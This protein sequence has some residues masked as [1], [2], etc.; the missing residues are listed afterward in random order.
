MHAHNPMHAHSETDWRH[1][2]AARKPGTKPKTAD[3]MMAAVGLI[4][5][6]TDDTAAIDSVVAALDDL[7]TEPTEHGGAPIDDE[8]PLLVLCVP[9]TVICEDGAEPVAFW[10][11]GDGGRRVELRKYAID[12]WRVIDSDGRTTT[13]QNMPAAFGQLIRA[14]HFRALGWWTAKAT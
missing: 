5:R 10:Q 9:G 2:V 13:H 11:L 4:D 7:P 1:P 14:F 3:E 8:A 12:D 6:P